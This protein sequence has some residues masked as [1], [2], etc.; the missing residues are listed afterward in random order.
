MT[1]KSFILA[2]Q[3]FARSIFWWPRE[4]QDVLPEK[5]NIGPKMNARK[6]AVDHWRY[7]E[8]VLLRHG[9]GMGMAAVFIV[10]VVGVLRG[11]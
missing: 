8:G 9:G 10:A 1:A 11:C 7:V 4:G 6:L 2:A 5:S 3:L